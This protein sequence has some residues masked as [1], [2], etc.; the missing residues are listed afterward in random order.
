MSEECMMSNKWFP[1]KK[2]IKNSIDWKLHEFIAQENRNP[3]LSKEKRLN[4]YMYIDKTEAFFYFFLCELHDWL[5]KLA[6]SQGM[7][8]ID[9][10]IVW[11]PE[12]AKCLEASKN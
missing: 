2:E 5:S 9:G 11:N 6:N 1:M 4:R 3:R 7:W 12:L 10:P 8:K